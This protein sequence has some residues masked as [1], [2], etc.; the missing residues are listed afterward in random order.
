MATKLPPDDDP[1]WDEVASD[2]TAESK[3][4]DAYDVE[5][6][7]AERKMLKGDD[8]NA[9]IGKRLWLVK[10]KDYPLH[11]YFIYA[12]HSPTLHSATRAF[13]IRIC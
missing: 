4:E 12:S 11:R 1:E 7:L 13:C 8:I 3:Q 6:I 9:K 5:E 2:T 10:W